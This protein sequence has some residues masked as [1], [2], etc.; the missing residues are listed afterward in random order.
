[1]F[2]TLI[3][4]DTWSVK[5]IADSKLGCNAVTWAPFGATGSQVFVQPFFVRSNADCLV[6]E[7]D[8]DNQIMR[9]AVGSCEN[10]V[11]IYR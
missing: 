2:F 3:A 5:T 8:G 11:S 10:V 7:Q 6:L 1:M 9:V 4:D